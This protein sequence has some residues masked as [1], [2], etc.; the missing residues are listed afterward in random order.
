MASNRQLYVEIIGDDRSLQKA[1]KRSSESTAKLERNLS[2][3]TRGVAA[4]SGAFKGL[5]RSIAFASGAFLGGA[6][7]VFAAK[8]A[9]NAASTI[10]EET[11]K[12][13]VVF[14]AS[15]KQVQAWAKTLTTSFG[16][17][18][19]EAL[20]S[21][22]VFGNMFHS[23]N[24]GEADAAKMSER[25]V[26]LAADMASFN[27]ASP[28][29]TLAAL[30][31]GLAGQVRPLR[32]F[33]VF[34]SQDRIKQEA[35][36]AGIA[37]NASHLSANQKVLAAYNII[38]HDTA[39]QQGDVARNTGSLSVAQSKFSAAL[40]NTEATIG[41]AL[42]P[43]LT[44]V[45]NAMAKWLGKPENQKRIQHDTEKTAGVLGHVLQTTGAIAGEFKKWADNI[46]DAEKAAKSLSD[47]IS[48]R[49]FGGG[50]D[51]RVQVQPSSKPG[52]S[53]ADRQPG[54]SPGGA[55]SSA[56][57]GMEGA[58]ANIRWRASLNYRISLANDALSKALT[59]SGTKDDMVALVRLKSL[60]GQKIARTKDLKIRGQLYADL[61]NVNDQIDAID[62]KK[63]AD[64]KKLRDKELARH[65]AFRKDA[66]DQSDEVDREFSKMLAA[67]KTAAAKLKAKLK[68]ATDAVR[69]QIG[70]LF[71][72]PILNPTVSAAK[73]ILGV[74]GGSSPTIG[75]LVKDVVAQTAAFVVRNNDLA[76]LA[77]AGAPGALLKQLREGGDSALIHTL[78]TGSKAAQS[79]LFKAVIAQEKVIQQ[80]A[81]ADIQARTV[82][83]H[84]GNVR[85]TSVTP[86]SQR[87]GRGAGIVQGGYLRGD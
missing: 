43:T 54:L 46:H 37:K 57:V 47:T 85:H 86:Q 19:G 40:Q 53:T 73:G 45:I 10:Q 87:R 27:N 82:V 52:Q 84:S 22:G 50:F 65:K 3:A 17:S 67:Q 34:L 35:L 61:K 36:S 13:G 5:G 2:G 58:V 38:L 11:E 31:S 72:G 83:V 49:I 79:R 6:G 26:T 64:E 69:T 42:L 7:F 39:L 24:I 55:G 78:A 81:H 8:S 1:Y 23:L 28:E 68:T 77:R 71:Q 56:G 18:E 21:T 63:T 74:T 60:I 4:G 33:G 25:L 66:Q 75:S 48:N 76:K 12:T 41:K 15:A 20:K 14:G 44:K 51:P 30:Q 62:A 16:I 29:E 9:I 59:T 80:I 70:D 32:Q